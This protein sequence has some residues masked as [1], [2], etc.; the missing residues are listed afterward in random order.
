MSRAQQAIRTNTTFVN[1]QPA[2]RPLTRLETEF[3]GMLLHFTNYTQAD[4]MAIS[5]PRQRA[6]FEGIAASAVC[7][8]VYRAF[9]ILFEDLAPLRL[10]GRVVFR[11]LSQF[12]TES[13]K[14]KHVELEFILNTTG[15][16]RSDVRQLEEIRLMFVSTAS[17][18]NGAP[19]LTLEQVADS[20][21]LTMAAT[22]VLG[23]E[24]LDDLL[25]QLDADQDG[26]L[27]FVELM[28]GLWKC[29]EQF[30]GIE[31]CNPQA[32]LHNLLLELNE[33]PIQMN[34]DMRLNK[35]FSDRYDDMV[36]SFVQWE[37][38]LP[39]PKPDESRRMQVIRGCFVG[40]KV[41][42]V[43][44]ALRIVYCDYA[45]LRVAGDI[46]FKLVR[47]RLS[48]KKGRNPKE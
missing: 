35:K 9:E 46:I 38:L 33:R 43:V 18:W 5:D 16:L 42:E 4:I 39:E 32:V 44:N 23:F 40:A 7:V 36:T 10:A 17:Q 21:I 11:R 48:H 19:H 26:K 45:G 34:P 25:N 15:V 20:G 22:Q 30:C 37:H 3:R 31:H 29:S 8:P 14:Q 1:L 47:S 12:M 24:T 2:K 6:L 27:T 41:P 28:T 13:L